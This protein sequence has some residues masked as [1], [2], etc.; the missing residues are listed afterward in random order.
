MAM[1]SNP[2]SVAG[3]SAV[4]FVALGLGGMSTHAAADNE[5]VLT[6]LGAIYEGEVDGVPLGW[7]SQWGVSWATDINERGEVVGTSTVE[8]SSGVY[9]YHPFFWSSSG[10]MRDLGTMGGSDGRAYALNNLGQVVGYVG[11]GETSGDGDKAFL[12][13]KTTGQMQDLGNLVSD[14]DTTVGDTWA[15][16]RGINDAGQV[17]GE[18]SMFTDS[19]YENPKGAFIWDST[20]GIQNLRQDVSDPLVPE[21]NGAAGINNAGQI[22]GEDDSSGPRAFLLTPKDGEPGYDYVN[23]GW[24][25]AG[26][27]N[28]LATT[29]HGV[30]DAGQVVGE[31]LDNEG[32]GARRKAFVWNP[33]TQTITNLGRTTDLGAYE[34]GKATDI[35]NQGTIIGKLDNFA[36]EPVQ[37]GDLSTGVIW[38]PDAGE[39]VRLKT[40]TNMNGFFDIEDAAAINDRG[41]IVGQAVTHD[42]NNSSN[43]DIFRRHAVLLNPVLTEDVLSGGQAG[44]YIETD[45]WSSG[46]YSATTLPGLATPIDKTVHLYELAID[47]DFA[48]LKVGYTDDE[49]DAAS[50]DETDLR[51]YWLD[52][53]T[54]N[55]LLAG[56]QANLVKNPDAMFVLD[57]PT[58]NLGDWGVDTVNNIVW[59]NIDH[60]SVYSIATVPEVPEPATLGLV[61][62]G[63]LALLRRRH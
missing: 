10:G 48:T 33:D 21:F 57:A 28:R 52:E 47:G 1:R 36:N 16:A 42:Q 19:I 56:D 39:W 43:Y 7:A 4:F 12:W 61:A 18:S 2:W 26:E 24:L 13:D 45:G 9:E 63:A 40:I 11:D 29:A 60:A 37:Y 38:D 23:L 6:D 55:W 41:Q 53:S 22:I 49:I 62:L 32:S 34:F 50:L 46:Q 5:Y 44:G 3:L 54:G 58:A 14:P 25:G 30:N 17:V 8:V 59:A 51:L 35:N 20:N 27:T 31:S 15:R